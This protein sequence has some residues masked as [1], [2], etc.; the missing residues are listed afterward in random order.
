MRI[1]PSGGVPTL[2]SGRSSGQAILS[3]LPLLSGRSGRTALAAYRQPY[4]R[5]LHD[6]HIVALPAAA[7]DLQLAD[8]IVLG[9]AVSRPR[10]PRGQRRLGAIFRVI[11]V[12]DRLL[13][14]MM[15]AVDGCR[16]TAAAAAE[17]DDADQDENRQ[18][19]SRRVGHCSGVR[20]LQFDDLWRRGYNT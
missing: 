19:D 3:A 9:A 13:V 15:I 12:D 6:A 7:V 17:R 4:G 8:A 11:V 14:V 16:S 20:L 10:R 5:R 18:N 2:L 1:Y